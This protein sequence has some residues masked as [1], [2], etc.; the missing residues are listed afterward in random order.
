MKIVRLHNSDYRSISGAVWHDGI[1]PRIDGR[2]ITVL[3]GANGAGKSNLLEQ[4]RWMFVDAIERDAGPPQ[5]HGGSAYTANSV[6]GW[7]LVELDRAWTEH[8]VEQ[9]ILWHFLSH[10]SSWNIIL[11]HDEPQRRCIT[12]ELLAKAKAARRD[13]PGPCPGTTALE[14]LICL[15]AEV[16]GAADQNAEE[17]DR[18]LLAEE[19]LRQAVIAVGFVDAQAYFVPA[20]LSP[21]ARA[22][23]VRV[24]EAGSNWRGEDPVLEIAKRTLDHSSLEKPW[25][26]IDGWEYTPIRIDELLQSVTYIGTNTDDL[27]TELERELPDV[28]NSVQLSRRANALMPDFVSSRGRL[29]VDEEDGERTVLFREHEDPDQPYLL[30]DLGE[31]IKRWATIA[32]LLAARE[33]RTGRPGFYLLDEPEA[34]LHLTAIRSLRR[35]LVDRNREGNGIVTATHALELLDLP[36]ELAEFVVVTRREGVTWFTSITESVVQ[37]LS[38]DAVELGIERGDAFRTLR[39]FLFVEGLHDVLVINHFFRR[40]LQRSRILMLPI[41]GTSN[42]RALGE[43]EYLS[44]LNLPIAFLLDNVRANFAKRPRREWTSEEQKIAALRSELGDRIRI[45]SHG[46]PDIIFALPEDAVRKI[47]PSFTDWATVRRNYDGLKKPAKLKMHLGNELGLTDNE[48]FTKEPNAA[49]LREVLAA[50]G[51]NEKV[52]SGLGRAVTEAVAH[53]NTRQFPL[54]S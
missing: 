33:L 32:T 53:I 46:L 50:S 30:G 38:E 54:V 39:G 16:L 34:H 18:R 40:D 24:A 27:L 29:E 49:F 1:D 9:D 15:W 14:E 37:Q 10:R 28:A 6:P 43:M 41:Y 11:Y 4:I 44:R 17:E 2:L 36:T 47:R 20:R 31:G 45:V 51:E 25:C 22:A 19:A 35:W 23:A 42:A 5:R 12:E 13:N 48:G 52:D 26:F 21:A 8:D 3:F 7:A